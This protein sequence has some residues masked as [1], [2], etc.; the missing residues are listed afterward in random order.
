M[1]RGL[2]WLILSHVDPD[3]IG[4]GTI[5][6]FGCGGGASTMILARM[7]PR[8][9]IVGVEI[10]PGV[11]SIAHA[12]RDHYGYENVELHLAKSATRVG[13]D[14]GPVDGIVLDGLA[15]RAARAFSPRVP[16]NQGWDDLL[17]RGIR[18]ATRAEIL[19]AVRRGS[20]E[21]PVV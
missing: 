6:D 19:A 21:E 12:R 1:Q 14:V 16:K 5:L 11:M 2:H 15:L 4:S 20:G 3:E 13:E 10:D 7:F 8:A 18:G 9:R 17:R